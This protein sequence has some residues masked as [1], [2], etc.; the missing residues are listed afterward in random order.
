MGHWQGAK[1][2]EDIIRYAHELGIKYL[3]LYAFSSEN[4]QRPPEEITA[5]ME[6]LENYLNNDPSELVKNGIR[7]ISIGEIDRLPPGLART[8]E[9]VMQNGL[10]L[11]VGYHACFVIWL[12]GRNYASV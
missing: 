11:K 10:L 6:I 7:I 9:N 2:A 5:V 12:V 4:W 8:L 1:T 3:T